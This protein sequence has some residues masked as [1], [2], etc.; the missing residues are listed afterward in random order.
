[1][2]SL[3]PFFEE[4]EPIGELDEDGVDIETPIIPNLDVPHEEKKKYEE[5]RS[6][7]YDYLQMITEIGHGLNIG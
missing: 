6:P 3:S 1:M 7:Q 2:G 4:S 5:S